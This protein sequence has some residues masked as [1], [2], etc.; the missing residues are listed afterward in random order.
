MIG[1]GMMRIATLNLNGYRAACTK[2]LWDWV[3]KNDID[4]LC[5]QE[6]RQDNLQEIPSDWYYSGHRNAAIFSHLPF[7]NHHIPEA[8]LR[9]YLVG[10]QFFNV[11]VWS[12]YAPTPQIYQEEDF[13][14]EFWA[15][16]LENTAIWIQDPCFLCGDLNII[17]SEKDIHPS[18]E[19]IALTK[20][21]I[22]NICKF[23]S[24]RSKTKL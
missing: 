3:L 7:Q 11:S 23:Y 24:K 18:Y 17:A 12:I 21:Y 6:I 1:R 2:G 5:A 10:V 15:L 13:R 20:V 9:P 19:G 8:R 22:E 14:E 16:F 4:V